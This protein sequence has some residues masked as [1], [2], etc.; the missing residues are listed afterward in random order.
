MALNVGFE[1]PRSNTGPKHSPEG[2]RTTPDPDILS[3]LHRL[4][5]EGRLYEVEDWIKKGK[6]IQAEPEAAKRQRNYSSALEIALGAGNHSLP[7]LLL[8]NGYD[9]NLEAD[10][11]LNMALEARRWDLLDLLLEW[12]ADPHQVD[13]EILFDTYETKL[14]ERFRNLG[15]NLTAGRELASAL[16]YH[17]SN[18]PLFGFAKRHRE[19]DPGI[20]AELNS[21]L[22]HHA[23]EGTEKGLMLCLWAGADPHAPAR[24]LRYWSYEDEEGEEE[25]EDTKGRFLGGVSRQGTT[26]ER[27]WPCD[28]PPPLVDGPLLHSRVAVPLHAAANL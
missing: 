7:L 25:E 2:G 5:K 13:L 15:V 22:A 19:S 28:Q 12:G 9:P 1:D 14:F 16:A 3:D 24:S 18:K 8:S 20:Q 23:S 17:T 27:R 6:P 11:P 10:S 21:A 26:P 4:C